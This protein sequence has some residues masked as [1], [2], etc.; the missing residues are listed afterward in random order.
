MAI[1]YQ[2]F[3]LIQNRKKQ[4]KCLFRKISI[5]LLKK[6]FWQ[7]RPKSF[8]FLFGEVFSSSSG[9]SLQG[10]WFKLCSFSPLLRLLQVT[11]SQGCCFPRSA[12]PC[13]FNACPQ[14]LEP[15][16]A[17]WAW[18]S[19]RHCWSG[20]VLCHSAS[21]ASLPPVLVL[22]QFLRER[23]PTLR[24]SQSSRTKEIIYSC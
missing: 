6:S 8:G 7:R 5:S 1:D 10:H 4:L 17:A 20:V 9:L 18:Q 3:S 13:K 12:H 16:D 14:E 2:N 22:H 21:W 15:L 24:Y 11:P 23:C 19:P